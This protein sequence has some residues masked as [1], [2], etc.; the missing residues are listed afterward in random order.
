M[1]VTDV[2]GLKGKKGLVIGIANDQSIA[3][4]C[5]RQ[6]RAL[7]AD[8]AVTT[9][10]LFSDSNLN[11]AILMHELRSLSFSGLSKKP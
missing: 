2:Y 7:G 6:F 1:S 11:N 9:R 8:L 10:S 3:Y 5:A 4:G